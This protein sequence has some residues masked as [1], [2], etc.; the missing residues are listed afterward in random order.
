MRRVWVAAVLGI[1]IG[2]GIAFSPTSVGPE[3]KSMLQLTGVDQP[4]RFAATSQPTYQYLLLA[5]AVGII[6]AMPIFLF[7][8]RRALGN[9]STS[10][11]RTSNFSKRQYLVCR[12]RLFCLL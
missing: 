7:S 12:E 1:I 8:R 5:L 4:A 9:V 6:V 2:L 3:E 10:K 11:A